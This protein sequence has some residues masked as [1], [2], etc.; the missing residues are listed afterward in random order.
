MFN[1]EYLSYALKLIFTINCFTERNLNMNIKLFRLV[2]D[3]AN[4][5][6]ILDKIMIIFSTYIPYLF[7]TV[8]AA[9][10]LLGL[11]KKDRN[12]RKIAVHTFIITVINLIISYVIGGIYYVNRPFVN[13]KVNLLIPHVEDASFPSDHATGTM[14]IAVGLGKDN[15]LLGTILTVLSLIVGF[16]RVYVGHHYPSDVIGAYMIVFVT[17][18]MYSYVFK[19]KIDRLYDKIEG[20]ILKK[21][22][23]NNLL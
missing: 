15:K 10:L 19:N 1:I 18:Y 22:K 3:L 8:L 20:I 23:M 4:K 7:M 16:S 13:N 17:N 21:F 5:N 11:V 6:I 14:S 2:N 12:T 9:V